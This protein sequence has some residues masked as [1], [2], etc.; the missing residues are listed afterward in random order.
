V[1][2]GALEEDLRG[3]WLGLEALKA[4]KEHVLHFLPQSDSPWPKR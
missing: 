4:S 1:L 2:L 3:Y